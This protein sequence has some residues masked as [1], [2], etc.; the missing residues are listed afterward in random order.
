MGTN[1]LVLFDANE[2]ILNVG[3]SVNTMWG[4][5]ICLAQCGQLQVYTRL[6]NFNKLNFDE[7]I[8]LMVLTIQTHEK[9][10]NKT[11]IVTK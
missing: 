9:S 4:F 5:G 2:L 6:T 10:T 1:T 3:Q 11:H 7:L 8:T